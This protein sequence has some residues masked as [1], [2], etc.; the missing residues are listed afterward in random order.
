MSRYHR[1]GGPIQNLAEAL[2]MSGD[3]G[4][5]GRLAL[6]LIGLIVMVGIAVGTW[7]GVKA[8][9]RVAPTVLVQSLSSPDES[10]LTS[11]ET[12]FAPKPEVWPEV[13]PAA[14]SEANSDPVAIPELRPGL[15]E[16]MMKIA[17]VR[18]EEDFPETFDLNESPA[19]TPVNE[20]AFVPM[21]TSAAPA[22]ILPE[23][24][25]PAPTLPAPTL[26]VPV[27]AR[28]ALIIDDLGL[29]EAR[30]RQ[31][32]DLPAVLT[33]SWLPYAEHI[34][35]QTQY[36]FERGHQI[37]AHV[38]MQPGGDEDPGPNA[39]MTWHGRSEIKSLLDVQLSE[40]AGL[41]G[42]NNHMGSRFTRNAM[43]MGW[44]MAE[45]KDR[46]LLFVD[47][48]TSPRS[49]GATVA[50]AYGLPFLKRDFFID[51]DAKGNAPLVEKRL[52]QLEALA[53]ERGEVI[54]IGHPYVETLAGLETW[55]PAAKARG[56]EFITVSRLTAAQPHPDE[57]QVAQ[58]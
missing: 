25:L 16:A 48:L 26:S 31:I 58:Q 7:A 33:L 46:D 36:G 56:I 51:H 3:S 55:I 22:L 50:K 29:N 34:R 2:G 27:K 28:I 40:F 41:T 15:P 32:A 38:P 13:A 39:L 43:S 10:D 42:I 53:L 47:S 24:T 37:F 4:E 18:F 5:T 12:S 30:A 17:S 52:A 6:R 11:A 54:A 45:V 1:N 20:P 44:L 35:D 23:P 19:I 57:M 14:L 8:A 49:E 9:A 21:Q